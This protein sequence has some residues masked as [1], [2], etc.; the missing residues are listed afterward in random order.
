MAESSN[1]DQAIGFNAV[2]NTKL[3]SLV[4]WEDGELS[5]KE[6][7]AGLADQT[8]LEVVISNSTLKMIQNV[9]IIKIV[10]KRLVFGKTNL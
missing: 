6:K 5:G 1:N 4:P 9:G 8:S 10:L 3:T 2:K 7:I